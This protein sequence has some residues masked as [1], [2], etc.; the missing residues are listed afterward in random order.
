MKPELKRR[1]IRREVIKMR[2]KLLSGLNFKRKEVKMMKKVMLIALVVLFV[3]MMAVQ[4][5]FAVPVKFTFVDLFGWGRVYQPVNPPAGIWIPTN[6]NPYDGTWTQ[7]L[8]MGVPVLGDN[9]EDTFT[10]A[11]IERLTSADGLTSYWDRSTSGQEL[12]VFAWGFDDIYLSPPDLF[13]GTATLAAIGGH[14]ELWL[15]L[16]PDYNPN[17]GTPGRSNPIDPSHYDNVTDDGILV[18]DILPH[19]NPLNGASFIESANFVNNAYMG[20]ML[21]DVVG[22]SWQPWFDTNGALDG[23]DFLYSWSASGNYPAPPGP[24]V[25]DWLI[26]DDSTAYGDLIPEPGTILLMGVGLIGIGI[27]GHRRFRR[28]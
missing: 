5:A 18:L 2:N 27:A 7:N 20:S 25:A 10:I 1:E 28:K 26:Y 9:T 17:F 23:A 11:Q 12:T 8:P 22:G 21:L 13:A 19:P 6:P 3:G 24:G 15:D 4:S 14:I 16:T